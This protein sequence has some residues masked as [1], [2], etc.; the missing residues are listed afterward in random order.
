VEWGARAIK[1][2]VAREDFFALSK[3]CMTTGIVW[4]ELEVIKD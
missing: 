4:I 1:G 2:M 3:Y